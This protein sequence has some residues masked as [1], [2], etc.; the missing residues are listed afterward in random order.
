MSRRVILQGP[1]A[2]LGFSVDAEGAFS[3]G[4]MVISG[5]YPRGAFRRYV[6][7]DGTAAGGCPRSL[8]GVAHEQA[9]P[10]GHE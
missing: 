6:R 4:E 2:H 1:A 10:P 5:R 8:G 3:A 7:E 9:K